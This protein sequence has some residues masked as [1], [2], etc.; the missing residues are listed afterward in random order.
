MEREHGIE[1]KDIYYLHENHRHFDLDTCKTK[2]YCCHNYVQIG[3][4]AH[5]IFQRLITVVIMHKVVLKPITISQEFDDFMSW[6][7]RKRLIKST[8]AK[9]NISS[10]PVIEIVQYQR[11]R[12][13]VVHTHCATFPYALGRACPHLSIFY[14]CM[15]TLHTLIHTHVDIQNINFETTYE[16]LAY[17]MCSY[18]IYHF[19]IDWKFKYTRFIKLVCI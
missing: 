19:I 17:V 12:L 6:S 1:H 5:T 2:H 14:T 13:G 10:F 15:Y 16:K 18:A 4:R 9:T 11:H 8:F 3:L 7:L